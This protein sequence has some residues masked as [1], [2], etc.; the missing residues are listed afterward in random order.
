MHGV[1]FDIERQVVEPTQ[2]GGQRERE[3]CAGTETGVGRN[4][5]RNLHAVLAVE[6]EPALHRLQVLPHAIALR[7][8]DFGVLCAS[9]RDARSQIAD[10]KPDAAKAPTE[11]SI[12][13][14][15]A[16]MQPGRNRG[17]NIGRLENPAVQ[18]L[19]PEIVTRRV[20][21]MRIQVYTA[22]SHPGWQ[23]EQDQRCSG[24]RPWPKPKNEPIRT[25]KFNSA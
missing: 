8:A 4:D 5:V 11:P 9:D 13:V 25:K 10:G 15:K 24:G 1:A 22:S 19:A 12:E 2:A 6:C 16:E 14:D 7:T 3:L 23:S 21:P 20:F 17:G 18:T